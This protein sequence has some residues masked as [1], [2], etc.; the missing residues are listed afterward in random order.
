[1]Q[2]ILDETSAFAKRLLA[3]SKTLQ[4]AEKKSPDYVPGS[5]SWRPGDPLPEQFK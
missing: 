4:E 5:G 3:M 2:K 1:M